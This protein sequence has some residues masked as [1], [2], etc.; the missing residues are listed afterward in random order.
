MCTNICI[1]GKMRSCKKNP[2]KPRLGSERNTNLK[3]MFLA[4]SMKLQVGLILNTRAKSNTLDHEIWE[5]RKP[6]KQ[7]QRS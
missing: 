4:K 2:N 1:Y 6:V 7:Q 3:M 5:D